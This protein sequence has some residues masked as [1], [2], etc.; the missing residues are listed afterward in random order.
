MHKN[1]D[2][3]KGSLLSLTQS[4]DIYSDTSFNPHDDDSIERMTVLG[5]QLPNP[6]LIPNMQQAYLDLGYD[7]A[8]ATVTNLYVRF[9]PTVDQL[10]SLDSIMDS[11]G[12]DLFDE[13]MDYQI[14]SEGD[15]YQDPSIPDS[16]P[17]WQYAVVTPNFV[18]PSG[19]T[20]QVLAQIHIPPDDYTAIETEAENIAGGGGQQ[21]QVQGGGSVSPYVPQCGPGYHWDYTLLKCVPNNCPAGYHW[22]NG[23]AKCVPNT[24]PSGYYWDNTSNSCLPYNT[25]PPPPAPD[26]AIPAGYIKVNDTQLSATQTFQDGLPVR[27]ARVVAKRWFKIQ[28]VYTDDN[29]YFACTVRFKH[30]VKIITKFKNDDARIYGIR[31]V[32]LWQMIFPVKKVLGIYSG[33]KSNIQFIFNPTSSIS[34]KGNRY[35][36]AATTQNIVQEHKAYASQFGFSVAPD[37]LNIYLTNW[38]LTEGLSS[39][40]LF[41][42][43]YGKD[44]P[45]SFFN[46]FLV[47]APT[48]VVAGGLAACAAIFARVNVDMAINYRT[49]INSFKSDW[50]KELIYHE[51]SHASQYS[52]V[53]TNWYSQFVNAELAEIVKFPSGKYNPYG[54]GGSSNS[55]IIALGEG[56]AYHMGHYLADQRY[57]VNASCANEGQQYSYC[58]NPNDIP[59][60]TKY[61]HIDVLEYFFP[62]YSSDNFRWIP[63]GLM[64]DLMDTGE[65]SYYTLVNDQVSGITISQLFAALQSDV[66][67]VPQYKARLL[68]QLNANNT[69]TTNI[70]NLFASYNY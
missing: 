52:K 15:Y 29:G 25:N 48:Y 22:D 20:Y 8:R 69:L 23:Q 43:R 3:T 13:P 47:A 28:R 4:T 33:D 39:T 19:I 9:K 45:A 27:K 60:L 51:L 5:P 40:P 34:S 36:V 18:P 64:E 7:P 12:Y 55:P 42:K 67:T 24:C 26:A 17:T 37:H 68:Q 41:H 11:Q 65:P 30:K 62:N 70:N 66:T 10:A 46:T 56:W 32:R 57:G 38:G 54:D 44:M 63:K 53:G 21:A 35:W 61:P 59:P 14:I 31:G 50:I 2:G 49:N 16:L 6:Y 1:A 58:P